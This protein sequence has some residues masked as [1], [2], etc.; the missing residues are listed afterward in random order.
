MILGYMRLGYEVERYDKSR[1]ASNKMKE[2]MKNERDAADGR[3]INGIDR[4]M[5]EEG[6]RN[7]I[8]K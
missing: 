6:T 7:T 2:V 5:T 3:Q 1:R 8:G 4:K